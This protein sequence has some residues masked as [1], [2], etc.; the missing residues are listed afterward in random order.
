VDWWGWFDRPLPTLAV[1][2][3]REYRYGLAS[4]FFGITACRALQ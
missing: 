4:A 3:K 1:S 2:I